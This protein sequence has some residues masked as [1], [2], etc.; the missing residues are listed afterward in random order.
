MGGWNG[1]VRT[2]RELGEEGVG[3]G[4]FNPSVIGGFRC[5]FYFI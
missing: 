5:L 1:L 4:R 3:G 2:E